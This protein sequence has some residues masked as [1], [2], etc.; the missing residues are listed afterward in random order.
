MLFKVKT[1]ALPLQ[2]AVQPIETLRS[3]NTIDDLRQLDSSLVAT[4]EAIYVKGYYQPGDHGGGMF[5]WSPQMTIAIDQNG[6]G[7]DD[8]PDDFG[9]TV[10]APA[11][12]T[13]PGQLGRWVRVFDGGVLHTLWFGIV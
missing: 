5:V 9:G 10:L 4:F 13:T 1:P 12:V 3:V 11:T 7:I 2:T 8:A 6:D